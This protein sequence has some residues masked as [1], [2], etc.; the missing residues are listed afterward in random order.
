MKRIVATAMA[1]LMVLGMLSFTLCVTGVY[2]EREEEVAREVIDDPMVVSASMIRSE[3]VTIREEIAE[4][5]TVETEEEPEPEREWHEVGKCRITHYCPCSRC[6]GQWANGITATGTT[7]KEGRTIAVD[8]KI[9]P[10][11]SEVMIHDL[12]YIAEDTGVSG[13]AVDIYLNDHQHCLNEGLYTATVYWRE[14]ST[15]E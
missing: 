10:L 7:A 11:G 15:E 4:P 12:V 6:C 8:P 1:A 3:Q 5:E 13:N 9:I 2:E 14:P